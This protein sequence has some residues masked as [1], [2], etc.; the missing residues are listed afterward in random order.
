MNELVFLTD[1]SVSAKLYTTGDVIAQYAGMTHRAINDNIETYKKD[2]QDFGVLTFETLK[3]PK[4]SKGGRPRKVWH[5]NMLQATTLIALLGNSRP[6]VFLKKALVKQF[7]EMR[8]A[9]ISRRW[10]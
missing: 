3:P 5:L 9:L 1:G 10:G 8:E 6:I 4:G 2:L 7:Y